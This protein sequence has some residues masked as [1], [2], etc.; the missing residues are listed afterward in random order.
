MPAYKFSTDD[1]YNPFVQASMKAKMGKNYAFDGRLYGQ[2]KTKSEIAYY[3][4]FV[5]R[6]NVSLVSWTASTI[7]IELEVKDIVE[8]EQYGIQKEGCR[9]IINS[10]M[11]LVGTSIYIKVN[12]LGRIQKVYNL[13]DLS[14]ITNKKSLGE[15]EAIELLELNP[16]ISAFLCGNIDQ[17]TVAK[18]LHSYIV[19][20]LKVD[21]ELKV[22]TKKQMLNKGIGTIITTKQVS[23]NKG[24]I[25]EMKDNLPKDELYSQSMIA[26]C[27]KGVENVLPYSI[28][29]S[30]EESC[31]DGENVFVSVGIEK[32]VQKQDLNFTERLYSSVLKKLSSFLHV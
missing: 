31:G 4:D 14:R 2:A 25:L 17:T 18:P 28:R 19:P 29:Y 11:S 20:S 8:K 24:G 9:N 10:V 16:V 22:E 27:R 23:L 5:Y 13:S 1:I 6:L 7:D 3:I 15:A 26:S 32:L 21:G 30:M 12:N